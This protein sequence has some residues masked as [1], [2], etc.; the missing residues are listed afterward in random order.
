M[1]KFIRFLTTFTLGAIFGYAVCEH[2]Y[3]TID[4]KRLEAS[5]IMDEDDWVDKYMRYTSEE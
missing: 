5:I 3:K 1:K 2:I 4:K